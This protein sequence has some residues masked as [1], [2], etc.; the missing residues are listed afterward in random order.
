MVEGIKTIQ[1][2]FVDEIFNK[3]YAKKMRLAEKLN[4]SLSWEEFF[5]H[6]STKCK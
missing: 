3:L 4:L 2:K 1:V 6:L 5:L